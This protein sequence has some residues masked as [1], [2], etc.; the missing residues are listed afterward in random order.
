MTPVQIFD[1]ARAGGRSK[2]RAAPALCSRLHTGETDNDHCASATQ[3]QESTCRTVQP[4]RTAQRL[5]GLAWLCGTQHHLQTTTYPKRY[6]KDESP[7]NMRPFTPDQSNGIQTHTHTHTRKT[8]YPS[9]DS[10]G[11]LFSPLWFPLVRRAWG[12]FPGTGVPVVF[13]VPDSVGS[14]G[15][16][17]ANGHGTPRTLN[18]QLHVSHASARVSRPLVVCFRCAAV[19]STAPAATSAPTRPLLLYHSSAPVLFTGVN[20]AR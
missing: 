19:P 16:G 17:R 13:R 11:S 6:S 14:P 12:C 10:N 18:K 15:V 5:L 9:K 20:G 8:T 7:C 1:R 3:L 4:L 2:I